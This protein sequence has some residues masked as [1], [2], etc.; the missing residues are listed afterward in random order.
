MDDVI[1]CTVKELLVENTKN[2]LAVCENVVWNL[3]AK[4]MRVIDG[5]CICGEKCQKQLMFYRDMYIVLLHMS[6]ADTYKDVVLLPTSPSI[7]IKN[8]V[9]DEKYDPNWLYDQAIEDV[10]GMQVI[11]NTCNSVNFTAFFL[12]VT[13]SKAQ[14]HAQKVI[15]LEKQM[16]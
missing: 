4:D 11:L 16:Q 13:F 6:P 9:T 15:Q 10:L 1:Y 8:T 12:A 5:V 3:H 7:S 2:I 14:E